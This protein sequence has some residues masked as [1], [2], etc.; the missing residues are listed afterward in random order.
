MPVARAAVRRAGLR[1]D[2]RAS[3]TTSCRPTA[4]S[5]S[6]AR[7]PP[8]RQRRR[9][10]TVPDPLRGR[11]VRPARRRSSAPSSWPG[12]TDDGR[13]LINQFLLLGAVLFCIG[14]YGV[15]ARKNARAGADVDR[16]D[17]Q[18]GQ[19]QPG[20]LRRAARRRRR[21]RSSPC[22]SSPS[23]PPRSAS[24][25]RWCC[26]STA[27]ADRSTSTSSRD[28]G[29]RLSAHVVP[30][31][32][33]DHP[34][35]PG[36]RLRPHPL[37]RQ[38]P[39]AEGQRDRRRRRGAWR[40][41]L[42]LVVNVNWCRH[43]DARR[44]DAACRRATPSR[45]PVVRRGRAAARARSTSPAGRPQSW[46]WWS[47]TAASTFRLGML[48]DGLVGDDAAR[49]HPH[50]AAGAHLLDRLRRAATGATRTSSPFLSLFTAGD[51]RAW[52]SPRTRS[53]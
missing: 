13:L 48:L 24:A 8:Q 36:G 12:R 51:A 16:A 27:T 2:R 5:R 29:L 20:G 18:R 11:V 38:A 19:H 42:A 7:T 9:S 22:S 28:E 49:R 37:L 34:A 21:R 17:P 43:V 23:P 30:R 44:G 47:R 50:L 45:S 32:R 35:H 46:T 52:S 6:A 41:S 25:W 26:S 40:S 1:A 53:S 14:V 4:R 31:P 39:A 10:S 3:G 15:I 33:L